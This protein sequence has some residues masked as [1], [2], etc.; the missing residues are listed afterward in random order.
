MRIGVVTTSYPR[1]LDDP[2]GS[3]VAG[4]VDWLLRAGHAVDV[5]CAG[6][7]HTHW[8]PG[9][10]IHPVNAPPGLFYA[11]GAPE[12]LAGG[13]GAALADAARFSTALAATVARL[14][15]RWDLAFAHWLVPAAAAL[16]GLAPRLPVVAIAHSGDVH[17]VRRLGLATPLGALLARPGMR[18]AFVSEHVRDRFLTAVRS[19]P[20]RRRL[21]RAALVTPMGIDLAR[22]RAAAA[23][24][25]LAAAARPNDPR[26]VL[27]L[28]RLVPVKGAHIL[29]E[30]AARLPPPAS[31][32]D[33]VRRPVRLIV[34][35][36]GPCRDALETQAAPL[37][38]ASPA[39]SQPPLQSDH[40]SEMIIEFPGEVRGLARDRLLA[41][42]DLL[43]LPS[44]PV[45]GRRTEGLPVTVLEAMAA[46]VPVIAS[47]TGGLAELPAS[48]ATFVPAGDP[49]ALA[50]A[51][52][53]CLDDPTLRDRQTR[54]AAAWVEQHDWSRVGPRLWA[55]APCR[56][57]IFSFRNILK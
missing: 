9:A 13:R 7:G 28:G 11:G 55:H 22:F 38:T 32:N 42:A 21:E 47:R 35:G 3:F 50:R 51:V 15:R 16:A 48:T 54:A 20:L 25:R 40:S 10:R 37:R 36:D 2:A 12:R 52:A 18:L 53:Q 24:G 30:A 23:H 49:V 5:V 45:E 19:G 41:R 44:I 26:T 34:A 29:L 56:R 14:A 1:W 57:D 27:F 43:V 31:G 33:P 39:R 8:Q 6:A 4:H 17:L 46:G